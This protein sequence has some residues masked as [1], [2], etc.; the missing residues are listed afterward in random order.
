MLYIDKNA[1]KNIRA[2]EAHLKAVK[3]RLQKKYKNVICNDNDCKVCPT[4]RY[5]DDVPAVH[6]EFLE[7]IL[8]EDFSEIIIGGNPEELSIMS[9][10]VWDSIVDGFSWDELE[11]YIKV[12]GKKTKSDDEKEIVDRYKIHHDFFKTVFDYDSWFMNSADS[13]RYDAYD[14]AQNLDMNTCVYCNR[15]Y[16]STM[17]SRLKKKVMRPTF[18]H[19][20]SHAKHPI[21]GLSFYNLIPSCSICN[22]SVKG[23]KNFLLSTHYHPY[24]DKDCGS[25]F[26]YSYDYFKSTNIFDIKII[27][28]FSNVKSFRTTS[29]LKL[30]EMFNAHHSELADLIRIKKAYSENYIEKLK[31]VYSAINLSDMEVYRLAFGTE[32]DENSFHKRPLSKFKKDILKEL[33][34]LDFE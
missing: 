1:V 17:K 10:M 30:K 23:F 19:W 4:T 34:M 12:K 31:D 8:D 11:L 22:S 28:E 2:R 13:D 5:K 16:T 27:Q 15:L 6:E 14:L 7:I 9:E 26:K 33:K 20:V 24:V 3:C 18:D 25:S 29:D 21:L 32:I